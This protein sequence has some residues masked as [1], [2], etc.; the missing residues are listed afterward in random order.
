MFMWSLNRFG[1]NGGGGGGAGGGGNPGIQEMIDN[2]TAVKDALINLRTFCLT[3]DVFDGDNGER[4][5]KA[6]GSLLE[7]VA[8]MGEMLMRAYSTRA[9]SKTLDGVIGIG[10][11]LISLPGND[12]DKDHHVLLNYFYGR[13]HTHRY[14]KHQDGVYRE[15]VYE[16]HPTGAWQRVMDIEMFVR[17]EC[18]RNTNY[19]M[20]QRLTAHAGMVKFI[21]DVLSKN[22][23]QSFQAYVPDRGVRS[24]MNGVLFL[25]EELFLAYDDPRL[26]QREFTSAK[27]FDLEFDP[28][29]MD[30]VDPRSIPTPTFDDVLRQQDIPAMCWAW[31]YIFLFGRT[32][33]G[34]G[35]HDNLQCMPMVIG[36]AG[37]GKSTFGK[38]LAAMFNCEDVG[39]ISSNQQETFG[40]ETLFDPVQK[41]VA[42]CF[43][44]TEKF[45]MERGDL[46]SAIAGE[47]VTIN[48]KHKKSVSPDFLIPMVF[49]GNK[50]GPWYDESGQMG[51][52][53]IAIL[54]RNKVQQPDPN[55]EQK[56]LAEL[57]NMIYKANSLYLSMT[58]A[59][60][61]ANK[62]VW[63][64]LPKWF[65]DCRS[66]LQATLNPLVSF[67]HSNETVVLSANHW[68]PLTVFRQ[69][70]LDFC[71]SMNK[72]VDFT[73]EHYT[74]TFQDFRIELKQD[75]LPWGHAMEPVQQ[76]YLRGVCLK[77]D[78][79]QL[80]E[81]LQRTHGGGGGG[82]HAGVRPSPPA[83][84]P[85]QQRQQ[86]EARP[87]L[88]RRTRDTMNEGDA[89]AN[90]NNANN[91][92][93][94][95]PPLQRRRLVL[96]PNDNTRSSS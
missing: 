62:D 76:M 20:W 54:F 33:Y 83:A 86:E 88:G 47:K 95:G 81:Y 52:R 28:T 24:F 90:A 85:Q 7:Q 67:L 55:L 5:S 35:T 25:R 57:P 69:H 38:L 77:D 79:R 44:V 75:T 74:A 53:T 48:R 8:Q 9:V 49:F 32:L 61:Y 6:H 1:L 94:D 63:A 93:A 46:L 2:V 31:V 30:L 3:F 87:T 82:S 12:Q 34:V 14:R 72:R 10:D 40:L 16:G 18:D 51:R 15:I 37:T 21:V 36:R 66:T 29:I 65:Q 13:I 22:K 91:A 41:L 92:D 78:I 42:I 19:E 89:D 73:A 11:P 39:V 68:M 59:P 45:K 43:E 64:F 17:S 27:F 50:F 71:K 96:R 56:L 4:W 26:Q 80:D 58:T 84:L 23:D 60:A 70:Y